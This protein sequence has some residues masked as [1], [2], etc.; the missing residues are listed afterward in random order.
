M[1]EDEVTSADVFRLE[2]NYVMFEE[3]LVVAPNVLIMAV[4]IFDIP[5]M[6][7]RFRS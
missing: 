3:E 6:E 2:M 7:V 5:T 1:E 4:P